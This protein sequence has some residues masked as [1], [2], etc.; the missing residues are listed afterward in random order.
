M[1]MKFHLSNKTTKTKFNKKFL[2][3]QKFKQKRYKMTFKIEKI[4]MI[5]IYKD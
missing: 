4:Q 3:I 1:K 2:K 5:I